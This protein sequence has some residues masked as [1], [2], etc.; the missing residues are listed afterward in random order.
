MILAVSIGTPPDFTSGIIVWV[1]QKFYTIILL[2]YADERQ[3]AFNHEVGYSPA[4]FY[5]SVCLSRDRSRAVHCTE[6]TKANFSPRIT[7]G[8]GI[9]L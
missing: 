3:N 2:L 6:H 7:S 9:P 1:L 4:I 5:Y 8:Y